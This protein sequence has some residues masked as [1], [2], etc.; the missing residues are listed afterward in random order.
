MFFMVGQFLCWLALSATA[1]N[2][3]DRKNAQHNLLFLNARLLRPG[4]PL[5]KP[6]TLPVLALLVYA[7]SQQHLRFVTLLSNRLRFATICRKTHPVSSF[8]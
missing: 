2:T 4:F 5:N 8:F 7:D 3:P 1:D 6:H